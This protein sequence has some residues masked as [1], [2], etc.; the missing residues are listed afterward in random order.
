MAACFVQLRFAVLPAS[1]FIYFF[2]YLV[3]KIHDNS[4]QL[5]EYDLTVRVNLNFYCVH[6]FTGKSKL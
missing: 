1:I 3:S 6:T 5:H 2:N 4:S